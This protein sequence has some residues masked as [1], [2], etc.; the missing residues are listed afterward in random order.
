MIINVI[1]SSK[2]GGAELLV[3]ELHRLYKEKGFNSKVIYFSGSSAGLDEDELVIGLN[4]RNP[5]NIFRVREQIRKYLT[6][7]DVNIKV[8][9]HLTWPLYYVA[10][11][12]I[13]FRNVT[14]FYTEHNTTN[15]RRK[16]ILFR[17]FERFIY[18]RFSRI[19]CISQGVRSSLTPWVGRYLSDRL[20]TIPNG[21][22]IYPLVD[23]APLS[24]RKPNL[25]SIGSLTYKKNFATALQALGRIKNEFDTFTLVGEG[26]EYQ[27]LEKIILQEKLQNKVRL[28]GW[29][30]DIQEYLNAADIQIIPSLWEGFGLVA[31]EGMSTGLPV[32]SSNV[33]GLREVL[34]PENPA[35]TLVDEPDSI[36]AW[37]NA[38]SLAI[39]KLELQGHSILSKYSRQQAEQFTLESMADNYLQVY[40][41]G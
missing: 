20:V 25:V 30:D 5:L 33:A 34:N 22:R 2:G 14:L 16:I 39:V 13:G 1:S 27:S 8:H 32:V 10:L 29:S 18:A 31:V 9:V 19:I 17:Y 37:E 15:K 12:S 36:Q 40:R 38:I 11:A 24:G 7:S 26:P 28:V 4:P 35:V 21:S 6:D 3:R 23:R 41:E